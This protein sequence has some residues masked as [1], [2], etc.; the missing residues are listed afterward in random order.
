MRVRLPGA[1]PVAVIGVRRFV[2][3]MNAALVVMALS[4]ASSQASGQARW[5]IRDLGTLGDASEAVALN[6]RGQV[7]GWSS[8]RRERSP[9]HA[10]SW[11]NGRMRD[12]G[13]LGR[14]LGGD[15][16]NVSEAIAIN[17]RGQVVG[18]SSADQNRPVS[19]AF[20]W[21]DGRMSALAPGGGDSWAAAIDERGQVVGWRGD[22]L[23]HGRGRAFM[24]Q[25][26]RLRGL[27]VLPARSYSW[28]RALNERAEVVGESYSVDD[29]QDGVPVKTRAF[30]WRDGKMI[31]LGAL[32]GHRESSAVAINER[33]Q[34]LGSSWRLASNPA[35]RAFIWRAGKLVD[36]GDIRPI[37]IND[38][39]QVIANT[40]ADG[41]EGRAVLWQDGKRIFLPTLG[42]KGSEAVAING[43]GQ[44][45]GASAT[46]TNARHAVL[47]AN[48]RITDL[49]T[50]GGKNSRASAINDRG[51]IVGVSTTKDGTGHAV[52]WTARSG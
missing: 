30:L 9:R 47:W 13:T 10:F 14:D 16:P 8:L 41:D 44:I 7:V 12:L 46:P 15:M 34:I 35:G 31:D 6:E 4:G 32:P 18:N 50:L 39:G 51:Q 24:W 26:G 17:D 11:Q 29:A 43:R 37:A 36:L 52:L 1:E 25:N 48:G 3:L 2:L 28:A 19:D 38:R 27:G 22:D 45:V 21:E 49:G 33:G 23:G 20:V 42:G 5:V 40:G